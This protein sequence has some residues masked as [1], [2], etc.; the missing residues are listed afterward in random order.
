M[1][2]GADSCILQTCTHPY[3]GSLL[4]Q[5]SPFQ[6]VKL[7]E[8]FLCESLFPQRLHGQGHKPGCA[9]VHSGLWCHPPPHPA[10]PRQ[11]AVAAGLFRGALPSQRPQIGARLCVAEDVGGGALSRPPPA[12]HSWPQCCQEPCFPELTNREVR[13]CC[14][15]SPSPPDSLLL[16][17]TPR[18]EVWGSLKKGS[19]SS[20]GAS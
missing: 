17:G 13:H 20:L 3:K 7:G 1:W 6:I 12:L 11:L 2:G 5:P 4:K 14:C 19:A 8:R 15:C 9:E 10:S 18:E 16:P